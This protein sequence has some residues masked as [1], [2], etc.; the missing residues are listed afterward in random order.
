MIGRT[1]TFAGGK[2]I[3]TD[4]KRLNPDMFKPL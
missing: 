4:F 3:V 2:V 1:K